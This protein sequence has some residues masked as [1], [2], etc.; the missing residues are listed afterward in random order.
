MRNVPAELTD[1]GLFGSTA[2][3]GDLSIHAVVDLRRAWGRA[4]LERAFVAAI[5]AF[6]VLGRRYEPRLWRDAWTE[7]PGSV[8]DAVHVL[9]VPDATLEE[10]TLAWVRRPIDAERERPLRV[11]SLQRGE[12]SRLVVS[13]LHAAVDGAGA[14]AAAQVLGASLYGVAS[15]PTDRDRS[16]RHALGAL[17]PWHVPALLRDAARAALE[18]RRMLGAALRTRPYPEAPRSSASYRHLVIAADEL[19]RLRA[20]LDADAG[21]PSAKTSVNDLLVAGLARA[22]AARST[23]AGPSLVL[24]TMDLR[25]YG[26]GAKLTAANTSTIL[27]ALVPREATVDLVRA[28]AAVRAIT[29]QHRASLLGPGFVVGMGLLAAAIPHAL[30]RRLLPGFGA[31]VVDEPLRRGL[32]VTNVGRLDEGL[33]V[34]GDDLEEV[35]I[36]GPNLLNVP[37]PAV[38]A[39]G[40]RGA[41]HLELYAP[42]GLAEASLAELEHELRAALELP[43][44]SARDA[45]ADADAD[46][47]TAPR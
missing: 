43:A 4:A 29:A 12:R 1:V 47:A 35:R 23:G 2:R 19:A 3:Y 46:A 30:V 8:G 22:A 27:A 15:A 41:L 25:R 45:P 5:E 17:R 26:G 36:F 33:A 44:K 7:A 24:Y 31:S 37:I 16:V 11:V 6:P 42:P 28:V 18:P 13:V 20:R 34:F 10:E 14:A 9:Q 40:F 21:A 38:V 39:F 32:V